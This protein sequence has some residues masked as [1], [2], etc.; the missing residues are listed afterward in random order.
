MMKATQ[1]IIALIVGIACIGAYWLYSEWDVP[2]ERL[3]ETS[4]NAER[5]DASDDAKSAL[6][7]GADVDSRSVEDPKETDTR[8]S[9][10]DAPPA[11][12]GGPP[13]M[14]PEVVESQR[15]PQE[16]AAAWQAK[17]EARFD[18]TQEDSEAI[19]LNYATLGQHISETLVE[20]PVEV[21]LRCSSV[22]CFID[23]SG[24]IDQSRMV[25]AAFR[26]GWPAGGFERYMVGFAPDED[27]V[28]RH[29]AFRSGEIVTPR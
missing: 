25:T 13:L 27:G 5:I 6:A 2:T 29:V 16:F 1:L 11:E 8:E 24:G 19:R 18:E 23:V 9:T 3:T 10:V 22:L 28:T 20:L 21:E 12:E 4:A 26:S 15:S 14:A 7:F 17:I